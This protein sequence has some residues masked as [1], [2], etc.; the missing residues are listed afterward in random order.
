MGADSWRILYWSRVGCVEFIFKGVLG[1]LGGADFEGVGLPT[2]T[3]N[4]KIPEG[5]PLCRGG[6]CFR[7]ADTPEEKMTEWG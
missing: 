1:L 4:N 7:G 3:I 2:L 6:L 5:Y